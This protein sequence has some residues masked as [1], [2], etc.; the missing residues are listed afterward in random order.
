M[1]KLIALSTIL[2]A[3]SAQAQ[4]N[5]IDLYADTWVATDGVGRKTPTSEEAPLKTDKERTVGIFYI[6]WHTP[7]LHN[8]QPYKAD[9]SKVLAE[10]PNA[11]R[12]G[13]SPA[14]TIGSYHW[15]EPEYGYFLSQDK[16]VIRHDMS[17]LTD[18]G[19]DM[20][21][22]DVTN[23]AM[24]WAEWEV[25]FQTMEEMKAEGNKVP[26]FCFWSFNGDALRVVQE[27][28]DNVYKKNRYPDLWFYWDGKPLL[29][30]NAHPGM[31]ANP[32]AHAMGDYSQEVKD[33]F[34]LRGMWWGYYEWNGSRYVGTEDNWSFGY[35]LNDEKV[36]NLSPKELCA[37]H[38][39]RME[40]MA[41]TPAQHP[42]STV[43]KCWRRETGEPEMDQIDMPK[44]A[45]VPWLGEEREDPVQYGIYF[46]DRWDEAL[47]VDPDFIY[48]NDWNEWTAGKYPSGF[49]PGSTTAPGPDGFLDRKNPF[50]FVDQYNAEYNRTIS[51]MKGGY[52]D[53]YY[54]QMVQNIRKYKGVREIPR[55]KGFLNMQ[56]DGSFEDWKNSSVEYKDTRNDIVHRDHDGYGDLHYT[57]TTGRNDIVC[58]KVEMDKQNAYFYVETTDAMTSYKDPNWM[59]LFVDADSDSETGWEGYDFVINKKL[60]DTSHTSMMRWNDSKKEWVEIAELNYRQKGNQMEI[61]VPRKLLKAKGKEVT[62]DFKWADNPQTLDN[63]ISLCTD[64][65]AAPNRRFNFRFLWEK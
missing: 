33:F 13:N 58:S 52:T 63:I 44:K 29:L 39:G 54:M 8:G 43:G 65:D 14:W 51:P 25:M 30:Y 26:K 21:I 31:D 46:Q 53:N 6:T 47:S 17:M 10:D 3:L 5:I 55:N 28:Y 2:M 45:F 23:A 50:Y 57:N 56:I 34:T 42:I 62:F 7:N 12:D 9:V 36:S 35:Q 59:L 41:V 60:K 18:A 49:A 27:L 19:V 11:S 32:G 64:G 40:E 22:L 16:Y 4:E 48:L 24:Y 1:K 38:Q 61:C 37:T 15:G 20:I